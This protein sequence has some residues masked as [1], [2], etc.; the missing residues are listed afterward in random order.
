MIIDAGLAGQLGWSSGTAAHLVEREEAGEAWKIKMWP[1]GLDAS[2]TPT[3]AEP[4]N[5][6]IPLKSL[7]DNIQ[8][9]AQA[10]QEKPEAKTPEL[11]N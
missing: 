9:E 1:L 2:L 7:S 4:R 10:E 6:V 5:K 3:P 11:Q 8:V